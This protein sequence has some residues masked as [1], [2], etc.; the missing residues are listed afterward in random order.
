LFGS[1]LVPEL[2]PL[3]VGGWVVPV[4]GLVVV[5]VLLVPEVPIVPE[6]PVPLAPEM[7]LVPEELPEVPDDEELPMEL[8]LFGSVLG[9]AL[10]EELP[11]LGLVTLVL[12]V[13]VVADV[14]EVLEELELEPGAALGSVEVVPLLTPGVVV[15]PDCELSVPSVPELLVPLEAVPEVE[16][17]VPELPAVPVAPVLPELPVCANADPAASAATPTIVAANFPM[18]M[19]L[20][21]LVLRRVSTVTVQVNRGNRNNTIE[22]QSRARSYCG[23]QCTCVP[24]C[25][26]AASGQ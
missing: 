23:G 20:F 17:A 22:D 25:R 15:L 21:L 6:L 26:A 12:S 18:L 7:P 24:S 14:P 16:P 8:E 9:V 1:V 4:F 19:R 10:L 2:V 13:P 3:V 11:L 5:P